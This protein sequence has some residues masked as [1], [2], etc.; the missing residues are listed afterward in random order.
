MKKEKAKKRQKDCYEDTAE[1]LAAVDGA[2][3][4]VA[5]GE[6]ANEIDVE[7][8]FAR[9]QISRS[10]TPCT[11]LVVLHVRHASRKPLEHDEL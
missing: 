5:R 3:G 7:A 2:L 6:T 1:D 11:P 8:A 4:Q 9:L 10:P